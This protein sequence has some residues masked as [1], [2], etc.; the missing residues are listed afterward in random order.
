VL[1]D[2]GSVQRAK[3]EE[4]KQIFQAILFGVSKHCAGSFPTVVKH[5]VDV[6]DDQ[7]I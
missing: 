5:V 3:H 7:H 4:Q 6:V 2:E 1:T